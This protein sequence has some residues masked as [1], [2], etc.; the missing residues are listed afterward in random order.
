MDNKLNILDL[1]KRDYK[2]V[3]DL[4]KNIQQKRIKG[5]ISDTLILVEHNPVIT[6]GKSGKD[7]NLLFPPEH[8]KDKGIDFGDK[9]LEY[10]NK[11]IDIEKMHKNVHLPKIKRLIKRANYNNKK[12]LEIAMGYSK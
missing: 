1:K 12:S 6:M 9:L 3:W 5:D 8:L 7:D 10:R 2:E 11:A 4:Q